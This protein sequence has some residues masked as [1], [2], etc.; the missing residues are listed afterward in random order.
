MEYKIKDFD[1]RKIVNND[2]KLYHEFFM[3]LLAEAR[4][5][6]L[7]RPFEKFKKQITNIALDSEVKR[8]VIYQKDKIVSYAMLMIYLEGENSHIVDADIFTLP[9][10]RKRGM[11]KQLLKILYKYCRD[12]DL[13]VMEFSTF[14][15]TPYGSRFLEKIGAKLGKKEFVYQLDLS[16]V[17]EDLLEKWI[18]MAKERATEYRLELWENETSREKLADYVALYND[19]VNSEPMGDLDY[20]EEDFD[21]EHIRDEMSVNK[22]RGWKDWLLLARHI[23]TGILAGFTEVVYTGFDKE[24]MLQF[25]TGVLKEHRNKGLGRWLKAEMI[26]IIKD[27]MPDVKRIRS[28]NATINKP[29][30]R[31]NEQLGF[32][33]QYFEEYWH[34]DTKKVGEYVNN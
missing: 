19:F 14:S 28:H 32:I 4:P 33:V 16:K 34:I 31:I 1:V 18:N 22:K 20:E 29:M 11:A 17:K 6:D 12:N 15:T 10:Y 13:T 30:T 3:Q 5:E 25:G 7:P 9:E 26:S 8:W 21:V 27:K 24:L 2:L 23:P